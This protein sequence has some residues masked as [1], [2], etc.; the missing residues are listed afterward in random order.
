M[1]SYKAGRSGLWRSAILAADGGH[2]LPHRYNRR[3]VVAENEFFSIGETAITQWG[4]SDGSPVPGMGPDATAGNQPRGT[5]VVRNLVHELGLWTK[6]NS[7][8]FQSSSFGN[9]LEG[10]LAF[11]G[12]R[13]GINFDDGMGG[14][15]TITRN[16]LANFCR[17]SSDHGSSAGTSVEASGRLVLRTAGAFSAGP[18]NSW[19]RQGYVYD[20]DGAG[21]AP[22]VMKRNDTIS[23]NFMLANYHSSMAIDNDDGSAF[24]NTHHNVFVSASTNAAFGGSSLKNDFGGHSNFHHDNL[25]LFWSDGFGICPALPGFQDGYYGN[26][27]YLS[28][29]GDYGR[30]QACTG[31]AKTVVHGNTVWTPTGNVTECGKSLREWQAEGNDAGTTAAPYPPDHVVLAQARNTLRM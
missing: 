22:T 28:Q 29:D 16:V 24:Y 5:R 21:G 15:S 1:I 14:G 8:Y 3:A 26:Y 7:F 25:D 10:N 20:A 9:H 30:G 17:E 4:H 27:L 12:P 19:D 13:A 11:N 23:Y 31:S 2:L 18:F 6:Q